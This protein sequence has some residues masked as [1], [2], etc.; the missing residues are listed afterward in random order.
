MPNHHAS[1]L[2]SANTNPSSYCVFIGRFQPFHIGH[3]AVIELAL[4]QFDHLIVLIG[5]AGS[6][7]TPKNPFSYDERAQMIQGAFTLDD[8][9]TLTCLPLYDA[10]YNDQRWLQQVQRLVAGAVPAGSAVSMIG[11]D[12][13]ASSYYLSLMP[14]W[15]FVATQNFADGL[16]ATPLRH[17]YLDTGAIDGA[18]LPASTVQFLQDFLDTPT[19]ARL[20]QE[21][22]S[23]LAH[24]AS[25]QHAPYPPTFITADALVVMAGHILLIERGGDYGHGLWALAGGFVD[26]NEGFVDCAVRELREEAGLDLRAVP[27]KATA[28]F[29]A[30][31]RS[32]RGRTV[33]MAVHFE[34]QGNQL[35]ALNAGDDA[36]KAFWLPLHEIAP[37]RFF[38]DHYGIICQMLGL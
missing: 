1:H 9:K 24:H 6:A 23:L 19:Y 27:P 37:E 5:S 38:E 13:D 20:H 22:I 28:I 16:S 21:R 34:L 4:Q 14:Q 18:S 7:R 32:L 2:S 10:P 30:P 3:Q 17:A 25:W 31:D 29:D 33:T 11:Y 8:G 36:S 12:K 26:G 35:P 15:Q